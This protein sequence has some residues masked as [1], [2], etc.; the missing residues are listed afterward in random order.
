MRHALRA[1]R[2]DG[3][4][5]HI[6]LNAEVVR[7]RALVLGEGAAPDLILVRGMPR[8][9][10][11]LATPP[12]GLRVG[13]HHANRAAIM[14][15]VL[16][17]DRLRANPR[18]GEGHVLG[19]VARQVVADHEHVEVL[20][21]R[22]ARVGARGVRAAGQDVGVRDD[23]DDVGRVPAAGALGVV[24]VD[25]AAR[26]GGE[27]GLDV[28]GLVER[29]GVDEALHVH[30]VAHAQAGVDRRRRRAPVLVQL[31]PALPCGDLFAQGLWRAVVAFASDADVEGERVAGLEHLLRVVRAGRACGCGGAGAGCLVS[32]F[33]SFICVYKEN[34]EWGD[35]L[36]ETRRS[37]HETHLGPTPPPSKVVI[38]DAIDSYTCWGQI[39]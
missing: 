3:V 13:G 14:Q 37:H 21:E 27:G 12:H 20:V 4:L 39:K 1:R 35:K 32:D 25:G 11:D 23:G 7:A 28:P 18:L 24:G 31:E 22:V 19:D 15:H 34:E 26:D 33:T 9:Q 29:V 2:V 30:L 16:R 36:D 10:H 6:P 17:R 38:P 8:A 5:T